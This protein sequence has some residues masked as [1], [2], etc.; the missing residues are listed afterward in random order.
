MINDK[1]FDIKFR[2][3]SDR[4]FDN[5]MDATKYALYLSQESN[6]QEIKLERGVRYTGGDDYTW[7]TLNKISTPPHMRTKMLELDV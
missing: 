6:G 3:D 1:G 4:L 7:V 2:V 5:V